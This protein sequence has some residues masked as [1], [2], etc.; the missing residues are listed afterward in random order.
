MAEVKK[1][2]GGSHLNFTEI[3]VFSTLLLKTSFCF[4]SMFMLSFAYSIL[5]TH[6]E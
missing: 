6:G 5:V 3:N 2:N 1:V 4:S